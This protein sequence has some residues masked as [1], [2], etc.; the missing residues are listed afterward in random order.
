MFLSIMLADYRQRS[1]Q[2]SF[3]FTLLVVSWITLILYPST[4]AGY[5]VINVAGYRG[6]YNSA[7]LGATLGIINSMTMPFISFYLIKNTLLLDRRTHTDQL[8]AATPMN[9]FHYILGK[10]LSNAGILAS[11]YMTMAAVSIFVQFYHGED[12]NF[13]P[14]AFIL[15]Q[16]YMVLPV[17][18]TTAALGVFFECVPWLRKSAGNVIFMFIWTLQIVVM[19]EHNFGP[20]VILQQMESIL[21][22]MNVETGRL[23]IGFVP[24]EQPLKHFVMTTFVPTER[25]VI[26]IF[27]YL[28]LSFALLFISIIYYNRYEEK[29][30]S[31]L[32]KMTGANKKASSIE[33]I[34]KPTTYQLSSLPDYQKR[35]S[36]VRVITGELRLLVK[37][38]PQILWLLISIIQIILALVLPLSVSR[39]FLVLIFGIWAALSISS[40]GNRDLKANTLDIV[41]TSPLSESSRLICSW[42]SGVIL[43]L[44][45]AC[46]LLTRFLLEGET[47]LVIQLVVGCFFIAS[48]SISLGR[49]TGTARAYES[50]YILI[51]YMGPLNG[52]KTMDYLGNR[53]SSGESASMAIIFMI[54]S[55]ILMITL[56]A[57]TKIK[58][59]R[60][61]QFVVRYVINH[62]KPTTFPERH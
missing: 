15:P 60:Q 7:W 13:V 50:I 8:L 56:L 54:A 39:H 2:S 44:T 36:F 42:F 25:T 43:L 40:L 57:V 31:L 23:S 34:S 1:R 62:K 27:I 59:S 35:F 24:I 16:L 19:M 48:L 9:S 6:I 33:T 11:I 22:T 10:W 12:Y 29:G 20:E 32:D 28:F 30:S 17:L 52:M 41:G 45:L 37:S 58:N 18:L 49:L 5:A 4:Q 53:L 26:T 46:G 38:K 14:E 61:I 55:V 3:W 47:S 51:W 21:Q